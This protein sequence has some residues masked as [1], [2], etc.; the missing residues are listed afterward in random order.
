ML[1]GKHKQTISKPDFF[2]IFNSMFPIE[3]FKYL[4]GKNGKLRKGLTTDTELSC[5]LKDSPLSVLEL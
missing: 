3:V 4:Q 2:R 1:K 5:T